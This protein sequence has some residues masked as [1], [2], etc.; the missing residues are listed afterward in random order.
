[1][2]SL[3]LAFGH[4]AQPVLFAAVEVEGRALLGVVFQSEGLRQSNVFALFRLVEYMRVLVVGHYLA[5]LKLFPQYLFGLLD[6]F[7][8]HLCSQSFCL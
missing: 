1:M 2:A 4:L 8:D 7:L 5:C 6:L 3:F